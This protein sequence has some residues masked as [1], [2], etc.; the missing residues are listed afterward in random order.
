[1]MTDDGMALGVFGVGHWLV[2]V[3]M[4]AAF[5][6]PIGRILGRLGFSPFWSILAVIPLV[7]LFGLWALAFGDWPRERGYQKSDGR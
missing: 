2:F 1:M 3:A 5:L 4:L 6:Y 7:N